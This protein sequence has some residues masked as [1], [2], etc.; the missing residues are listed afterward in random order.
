MIQANSQFAQQFFL[1]NTIA[2]I[3]DFDNTLIPG[4][5]QRPLFDYYEVDERVFWQEVNALQKRYSGQG[6]TINQSTAYLNHILA[7]VKE[8]VFKNLRV[9]T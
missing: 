7:Y 2:L 5:M 4:A 3:W 6:I 8:D 9:F 1:Q